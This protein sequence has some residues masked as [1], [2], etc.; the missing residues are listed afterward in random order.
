MSFA[1][2]VLAWVTRIQ[3]MPCQSQQQMDDMEMALIRIYQP[4][5]NKLGLQ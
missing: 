4:V 3:V 1:L 2:M 5:L